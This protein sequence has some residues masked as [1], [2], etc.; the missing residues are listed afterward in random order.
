MLCIGHAAFAELER[1]TG[2]I[3]R[4]DGERL[5]LF[6][7]APDDDWRATPIAHN[8]AHSGSIVL[9]ERDRAILAGEHGK[10]A[11]VAMQLVLRM[12]EL[13]GAR[14][15]LDVTQVHIDGC[16]YTGPAFRASPSSCWTGTPRSAC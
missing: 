3:A 7:D 5:Q 8:D 2:A 10:A 11:Q 15:L 16:I 4:I 13:Q 12:A 14:E 1:H 6:T 9:S